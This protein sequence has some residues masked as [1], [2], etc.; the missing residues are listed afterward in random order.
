V[1]RPLH[2]VW[3]EGEITFYRSQQEPEVTSFKQV[4]LFDTTD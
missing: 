2:K 1:L 4:G 3:H